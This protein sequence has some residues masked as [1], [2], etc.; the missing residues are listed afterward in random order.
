MWNKLVRKYISK[1]NL[2]IEKYFLLP[3]A[4][5]CVLK[6]KKKFVW[7]IVKPSHCP[8]FWVS[9]TIWMALFDKKIQNQTERR[10]KIKKSLLSEK[11]LINCWLKIYLMEFVILENVPWTEIF[12]FGFLNFL[13]PPSAKV[14]RFKKIYP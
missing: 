13:T 3:K 6:I 1:P 2:A 12:L 14:N 10:E 4:K 8:P 9:R 11:L 7:H 5:H